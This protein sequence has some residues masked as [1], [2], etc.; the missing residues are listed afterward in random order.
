LLNPHHGQAS[1][2]TSFSMQRVRQAAVMSSEIL[3][4]PD[5]HGFLRIPG[6][7]VGAVTLAYQAMTELQPGFQP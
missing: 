2:N 7:P 1:H 6:Q 4:L 5:L 3:H